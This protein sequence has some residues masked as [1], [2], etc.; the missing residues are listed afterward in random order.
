MATGKS[1]SADQATIWLAPKDTVGGDLAANGKVITTLV[2]NY[3]ESGGAKENDSI[4][5]FG[6]AFVDRKVP[7]EQFEVSFDVTIRHGADSTLFDKIRADAVIEAD[8]AGADF[9]VGAV[10][11]QVTDGT[12][13]YWVAYNNVQA[14]NFDKEFSADEE[15]KGTL[16]FKLSP[17]DEDGVTNL[18]YGNTDTIVTELSAWS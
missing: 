9:V 1:L 10:M 5:H 15:L 11:I 7:Q 4:A 14:I 17:S 13:H 12:N 6:G 8:G 3:D 16:T 2:S 18:K